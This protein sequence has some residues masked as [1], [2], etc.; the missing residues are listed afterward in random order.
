MPQPRPDERGPGQGGN[1]PRTP[2]S[3]APKSGLQEN[4]RRG[5]NQAHGP[6]SNASSQQRCPLLVPAQVFLQTNRLGGDKETVK[7]EPETVEG[8]AHWDFWDIDAPFQP[9]WACKAR[10]ACS[11]SNLKKGPGGQGGGGGP[12]EG[13]ELHEQ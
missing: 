5:P 1:I 8:G 6:G 12:G 4:L 10:K 13:S 3:R 2:F 9:A 7:G 11:E